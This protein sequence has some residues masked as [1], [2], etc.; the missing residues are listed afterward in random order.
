MASE[1]TDYTS[2]FTTFT[3]EQGEEPKAWLDSRRDGN[4]MVSMLPF[5]LWISAR[6]AEYRAH[7]STL[8]REA[9]RAFDTTDQAIFDKW[10]CARAATPAP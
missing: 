3:R 7:L 1:S 9:R 10:L 6:W 8:P 5:S 2:R 4:G